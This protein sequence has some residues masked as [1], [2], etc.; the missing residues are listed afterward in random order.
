MELGGSHVIY[1]LVERFRLLY[2]IHIVHGFLHEPVTAT[3][4]YP[5]KKTSVVCLGI[6]HQRVMH[7]SGR[8]QHEIAGRHLVSGGSAFGIEYFHGDVALDEKIAFIIVVGVRFQG[9]KVLVGV[10]VDL[11]IRRYHVLSCVK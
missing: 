6:V 4:A 7:Y 1:V 5:E 9:R 8:N 2:Q 10:V 11:E 3:F